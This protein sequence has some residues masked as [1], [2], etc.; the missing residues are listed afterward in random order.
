MI[1][2]VASGVN[3][4]QQRPSDSR[5]IGCRHDNAWVGGSPLVRA[6]ITPDFSRYLRNSS[7]FESGVYKR[8]FMVSQAL[9][10][11]CTGTDLYKGLLV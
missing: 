9:R 10:C 8:Q 1:E 4:G 5:A 2:K 11:H 6:S 3:Q 7:F